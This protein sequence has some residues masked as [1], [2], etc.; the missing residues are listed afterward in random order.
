MS[1]GVRLNALVGRPL[2]DVG[3][4]EI[5][6]STAEAIGERN[7]IDV[8]V[9]FVGD[10]AIELEVEGSQLTATAA[11][12]ELRRL[13]DQWHRGRYDAPLWSAT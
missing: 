13:T 10:D 5:V 6:T 4:R 8:R 3:V 1:S 7:G 2:A 9:T 12:A 11:A